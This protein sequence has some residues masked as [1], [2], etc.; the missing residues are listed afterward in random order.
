MWALTAGRT[1]LRVVQNRGSLGTRVFV[2]ELASTSHRLLVTCEVVTYPVRDPPRT[3]CTRFAHCPASARTGCLFWLENPAESL[4]NP[5]AHAADR[6]PALS[7]AHPAS[8]RRA[9][10]PPHVPGRPSLSAGRWWWRQR[11]SSAAFPVCRIVHTQR[12][13][14]ASLPLLAGVLS[15]ARRWGWTRARALARIRASARARAKARTRARAWATM[16]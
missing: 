6:A 11:C 5:R 9:P 12:L 13:L 3:P 10:H 7:R 16:T 2:A 8:A 14:S 1:S 15:S 4:Q